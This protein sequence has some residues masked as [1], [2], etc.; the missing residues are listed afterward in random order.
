ML[1]RFLFFDGCPNSQESLVNLRTALGRLSIR[2]VLEIVEI[3]NADQ[4]AT[5][6]FLGSPSIM[7]DGLDLETGVAP[8]H[9]SFS[10]RLY[11]VSGKKTGLLDEQFIESRLRE[12]IGI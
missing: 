11:E 7:V 9:S 1:I 5:E 12:L 8:V 2:P 3:G 6:H 4:A 10:C